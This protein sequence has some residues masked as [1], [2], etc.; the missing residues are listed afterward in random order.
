M[1][2]FDFA[3]TAITQIADHI[4]IYASQHNASDIHFDP[5]ETGM[6]VRIRI[7]GDLQDY[8]YIPKAYERNLTTR[9]KLLANMNITESRLPQDGSIKGVIGGIELDMRVSSLP[10]NLGEKIVIRILDYSRSLAGLE[11]LGFN[12][13]NFTKLA[14]MIQVPN[15][16]ILITG[17]TGSGK[18]T[19]VYS[20]LQTL[21][22]KETNIITVEDPI[23]M[24]IEGM[25]QVQVNS[26][27]GLTFATVLRSILRQDPNIILIGEIRDSE[28]AQIAVRASITGHLVLSTIHTNNSL[29]TIER[30]LDMNVER[31]LLSSALTG[32]ISQRLAKK[33]CA[34]CRIERETT[35]YEKKIFQLVLQKEV[36][37]IFDV[38]PKGCPNCHNGYRG[39]LAI[40]EVLEIND[41]I[42]AALANENLE[43]DDIKTLVYESDVITLLQD[44]LL[45]VLE[46]LT[47]FEE[48]YRIIEIDTDTEESYGKKL[49]MTESPKTPP[50]PEESPKENA[51]DNPSPTVPTAVKEKEEAPQQNETTTTTPELPA[52]TSIPTIPVQATVPVVPTAPTAPAVVSNAETTTSPSQVAASPEPAVTTDSTTPTTVP[53]VTPAIPPVVTPNPPVSSSPQANNTETHN[54]LP[55]NLPT[56]PLPVNATFSMLPINKPL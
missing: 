17:A 27:I 7:D 1:V 18:S 49:T 11:S 55:R 50:T 20:I 12:K 42:R 38:N 30:L 21:N 25:N 9:L 29:A 6:M 51:T 37:K 26:E 15:G 32:I 34:K 56:Q 14:R 40:Q 46:G 23:E 2:T 36:E 8:T 54:D 41:S 48:I 10:T 39:R 45:K 19:T 3:K 22:K 5:R 35:A 31:Y 13:D 28:T 24:N 16:I 43:K 33:V 52:P 44:G 53:A 47:S 4:I